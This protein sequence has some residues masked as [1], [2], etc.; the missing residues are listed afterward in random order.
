MGFPLVPPS[1]TCCRLSPKV[2]KISCFFPREQNLR[3]TLPRREP[4]GQGEL[5]GCGDL[6]GGGFGGPPPSLSISRC[7]SGT[8][9]HFALGSGNARPVAPH[10]RGSRRGS[11]LLRGCSFSPGGGSPPTPTAAPHRH[12]HPLGLRVK[13]R[14]VPLPRR[15]D[16]TSP[17]CTP[18]PAQSSPPPALRH[19][20]PRDGAR[21]GGLAAARAPGCPQR[22]GR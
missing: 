16:P 22:G 9:R 19:R 1:R 15:L 17:A 5:R 7:H 10:A 20:P 8:F 18:T 21:A 12:D 2:L 14:G 4:A 13:R 6:R 11:A 3:Q